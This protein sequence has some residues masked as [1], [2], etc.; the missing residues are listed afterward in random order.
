MDVKLIT[1][2]VDELED[3]CHERLVG[4]LHKYEAQ[5][6]GFHGDP[7]RGNQPYQWSPTSTVTLTKLQ[8]KYLP[9]TVL[10]KAQLLRDG[11][12]RTVNLQVKKS[13]S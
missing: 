4:V 9:N 11:K 10:T 12:G 5:Q 7:V 8:W 1:G 6:G 13:P 3:W 2:T